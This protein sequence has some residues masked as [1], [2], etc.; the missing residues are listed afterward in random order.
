[1]TSE[2]PSVEYQLEFKGQK[3]PIRPK[4]LKLTDDGRSR[5]KN[6]FK[7]TTSFYSLHRIVFIVF[8]E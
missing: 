7:V 3:R 6:K 2:I 5:K 8:V 4:L 1:M